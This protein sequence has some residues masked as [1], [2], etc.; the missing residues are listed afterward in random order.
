MS[1]PMKKML[2]VVALVFG[3]IFGIYIFKKID[4]FLFLA[5]YQEP[6]ATISA[7]IAKASTWQSYLT[8]V[9]TLTAINGVDLSAAAG[10]IVKEIRFNSGQ[11][12]KQGD[13]LVLLDTAVEAAQLKNNLAQLKL[14]QFNYNRNKAL[15]V[16]SVVSQATLDTTFA[17]LQ[18]AQA[19][20]EQVQAQ[21]Q[22]KTIKA[23][24][25]GKIGIRLVN[26]GQY[27]SPGTPIVTLQALDPL[28]VQFN[29]PEQ[30]LPHLHLQ[31]PVEMTVHLLGEKSIKGIITAINSKVDQATRNVLVQATIPNSNLELYPGMFASVKIWL[32]QKNNVVTLPQTS[33]TYSLYGD[34]VFLI[35]EEGKD[36]QSHPLLRTYR[37]YIKVGEHRDSE[38]AILEGV[39]VGDNV[40]TSGQLKLRNGTHVVI[41]NTVEL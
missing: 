29:I 40:V 39:K 27:L 24:F 12:V 15:A 23:P 30:Y 11:F 34:S 33:I 26:L 9:G 19:S 41:D 25:S 1:R 5:N 37:Q 17:Q 35:K 22:Q 2:T 36:K 7:T 8:S 6:P 10:G 38:V 28:Y 16:K 31:Q 3:T 14:A 13:V 4:F 20:V 18:E 21:I 32:P